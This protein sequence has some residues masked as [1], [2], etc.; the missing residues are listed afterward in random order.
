MT[1]RKKNKRPGRTK[2]LGIWIIILI[3]FIGELFLSAW[4]RVQYLVVGYEISKEI[5]NQKNLIKLKNNLVIELASLKA[6][7]RIAK[8]A[9]NQL[10]LKTPT[11]DQV[12]VYD[13]N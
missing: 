1:K 12:I 7:E 10:G 5:Q 6:P 8:I 9:K 13:G 4:C 3:L 11:I 2:H